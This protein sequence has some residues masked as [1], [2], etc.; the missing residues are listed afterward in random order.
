[1]TGQAPYSKYIEDQLKMGAEVIITDTKTNEVL[2][3]F[4][5]FPD[6]PDLWEDYKRRIRENLERANKIIAAG[7]ARAKE[8]G[9]LGA[10]V[11]IRPVKK[12]ASVHK[13]SQR[14]LISSS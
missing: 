2:I 7:V 5:P 12:R 3:E 4:D 6:D 14:S 9:I 8:T 10:Q 13:S 1:L 11:V